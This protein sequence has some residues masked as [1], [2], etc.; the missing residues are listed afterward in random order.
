MSEMVIPARS[1]PLIAWL[2]ILLVLLAVIFFGVIPAWLKSQDLSEQIESGYK[3]LEK[4]RQVAMAAPELN[5]EY[6][7]IRQQGI[8]KLFYP[9]G[10]TAAQV[11]KEL[12]N[13]VAAVVA[14]QSGTLFSSEVVDEIQQQATSEEQQTSEYQRVTVQVVFQGKT[15]LLREVLHAAYASRPLIFVDGVE[16]KPLEGTDPKEQLVRVTVKIS[17]YWRGGS[18]A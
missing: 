5:A 6:E 11:G 13:Q 3:R 8:D 15:E 7:R 4:M 2:L 14:R 17:T 1:Q 16:V 10:M 12:Q 9:Q 18:K